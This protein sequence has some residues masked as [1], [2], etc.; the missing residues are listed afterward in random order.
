[1]DVFDFRDV[2]T[3]VFISIFAVFG[4]YHLLSYLVVRHKILLYYFILILGLALHWSLYFFVRN[5]F[6]NETSIVVE[7]SSLTTAMI[8]TLGLLLFTK[9]YLNIEK[10]N[11]PKLSYI[12]KIFFWIVLCLPFFH[13]MNKVVVGIGWLNDL[14]VMVAA[15]TSMAS[16]FLNI[17]S[18]IS[19]NAGHSVPPSPG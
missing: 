13:I 12:Y 18:G 19:G 10:N 15:L 3:I 16:I 17:F 8:T 11:H 1:M 4:I 9:N 7:R 2:T 14:F 5:S 6:A